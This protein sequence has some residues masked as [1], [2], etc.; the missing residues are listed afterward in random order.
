MCRDAGRNFANVKDVT[1][2]TPRA[3]LCSEDVLV[4]DFVEG[5]TMSPARVTSRFGSLQYLS[6]FGGPISRKVATRTRASFLISSHSDR[7]QFVLEVS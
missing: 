4:E 6:R 5:V 7:A 3:A 1:F 2:P